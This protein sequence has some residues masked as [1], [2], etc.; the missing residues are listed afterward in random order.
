MSLL[1]ATA[2]LVAGLL[3]LGSSPASRL[4]RLLPVPDRTASVSRRTRW[5]L[6]AL[7]GLVACLGGVFGGT[8]GAAISFA[9][10]A[11]V[12]TALRVWRRHVR[13]AAAATN[14]A[15]VAAACRLLAG[16]LRV[17]HVP[18][19]ALRVAARDS[20]LLAEVVAVQEVG[21]AVAPVLRQLGGRAGAAGLA[22]L[23]AAWEVAERTGASLSATLDAL[24]ER[25]AAAGAVTDVVSAELAAP[26]ATGRLLA[27][28]P[29][30]GL[31]LGYSL[32]GDPLA[33]LTGSTAGQLCLAVGVAL[34]CAGVIWTERIA[35]GDG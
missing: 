33:F 15:S 11:P 30:A 4:H 12:A 5:A 32:G 20:P 3:L 22:Q 27:V 23:G 6:P 19:A 31:L 34:G 9:A 26:R 18:A 1:A 7:L 28:L 17:G 16:L 25:L 8:A 29:L 35:G 2:V 21:G 13:T 10:G 14:A 24:A